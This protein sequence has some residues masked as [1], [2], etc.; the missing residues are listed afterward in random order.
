MIDTIYAELVCPFCGRQ[1]RHTPLS[2]YGQGKRECEWW[3]E[4]KLKQKIGLVKS[5]SFLI[6]AVSTSRDY[7]IFRR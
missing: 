4:G 5:V 3:K 2:Y 7:E 6:G 1:Y